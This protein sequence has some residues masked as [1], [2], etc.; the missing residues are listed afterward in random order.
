M[1]AFLAYFAF[2][3]FWLFVAA[4][5]DRSDLFSTFGLWFADDFHL[6]Q[7][8]RDLFSIR[9]LDGGT[10][11]VWLRNS[12][13]YSVSSAVIAGL[14]ATAAGY[15]FSKFAFRGRQVMFW[16]ILGSV[17]VPT[18]ALAVPTWL[19]FAQVDLTNSPLSVILPCSVSPFGVF[20]MRIYADRAIDSS[21]IEAARLDGASEWRIFRSIVFR[22]LAP[23]FVTVMLFAFVQTWNNYLLPLLMLSE[24]KWYPLTIGLTQIGN[25]GAIVGSL[26][27]IIPMILAFVLLQRF[28]Q[29][30]LAA[31]VD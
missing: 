17:M 26:I 21:L 20:L 31:G 29:T 14:C 28:W 13:L 15:G 8:V 25:S 19:L 12:F 7:N 27:A 16:V 2:P 3:L 24:S 5:K 11:V 6:V 23:G 18:Q 10:Y 30:G 1:L 22:L 9:T 4:T